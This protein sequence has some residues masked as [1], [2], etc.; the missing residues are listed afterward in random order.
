[1][2]RKEF[3]ARMNEAF[4]ESLREAQSWPSPVIDD[5]QVTWHE[6]RI[7]FQALDRLRADAG[8][9]A[10]CDHDGV[11]RL[12]AGGRNRCGRCLRDVEA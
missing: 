5:S 4:G 12:L 2:T 11:G 7:I 10:P 3:S 1:M 9:S 6:L 8:E